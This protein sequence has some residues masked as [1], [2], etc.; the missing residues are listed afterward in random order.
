MKRTLSLITLLSL[1]T[2]CNTAPKVD[3][4][5][6]LAKQPDIQ[7]SWEGQEEAPGVSGGFCSDVLCLDNG[8]PDWSAMT[9]TPFTNGTPITVHIATTLSIRELTL[10]LK[11]STTGNTIQ[12]N[13]PKTDEGNNTYL[14]SDAFKHTGNLIFSV[15]VNFEEGGYGQTYFP[16]AV[17]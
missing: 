4:Q 3:M 2:A 8:D 12:N 13:L 9:F 15:K 7:V 16:L 17:E 14:V 6:E 1:L 10:T 5:A 11:D